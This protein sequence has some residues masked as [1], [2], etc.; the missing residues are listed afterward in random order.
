MKTP[1]FSLLVPVYNVE[2]YLDT[3]VKSLVAQTYADCEIILLDDGSRDNS[4]AMCDAWAAKDERVR[5]IHRENRGLFTTRLDEIAAA[6]GEYIVF[7]DSDDYVREDLLAFLK[8]RIDAEG[9]DVVTY[10]RHIVGDQDVIQRIES[11]VYPDGT[12]FEADERHTI[13]MRYFQNNDLISVWSKCVKRTLMLEMLPELREYEGVNSGEDR[14][15]S[16]AI[17]SRFHRL[18]YTDEPLY[19]YR[20]IG[21]GISGMSHIKFFPDSLV[22]RAAR[23]HFMESCECAEKECVIARFWNREW[24]GAVY[25]LKEYV[26]FDAEKAL[27]RAAYR[28]TRRSI[29]EYGRCAVKYRLMMALMHPMFRIPMGFV[30]KKVWPR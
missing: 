9:C 16:A 17:L 23:H 24:H 29:R 28:Q 5:V 30:V 12:L 8:E 11:S 18:M 3:C 25:L 15:F 13:L 6:T 2:A 21:Q 10:G 22:C 1:F 14:I 20:R 27:Y 4:G 19:F 7:V 26:R